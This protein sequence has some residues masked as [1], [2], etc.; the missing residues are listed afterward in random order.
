MLLPKLQIIL[1]P[2]PTPNSHENAGYT[3]TNTN[4]KKIVLDILRSKI[5]QN[6]C[7]DNNIKRA[8]KYQNTQMN[9]KKIST[10][11]TPE[12]SNIYR[13]QNNHQKFTECMEEDQPGKPRV[14]EIIGQTNGSINVRKKQHQKSLQMREQTSSLAQHERAPPYIT[15]SD[16]T[17]VKAN[18]G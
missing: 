14:L 3:N 5:F 17:T 13:P 9:L 11:E 16:S 8:F 2:L 4:S 6:G 10:E 18:T 12:G 1:P 15:D 7:S